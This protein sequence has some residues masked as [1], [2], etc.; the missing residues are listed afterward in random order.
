MTKYR[1]QIGTVLFSYLTSSP[2]FNGKPTGKHELTLILDEEQAVDAENAGLGIKR[3]EYNGSEQVTVKLTS[4][5]KLSADSVRDRYKNPYIGEDGQIKEIPKGST[6]C[7]HYTT[8]EYNIGGKVIANYLSGVQ[9]IEENSALEF[10]DYEES[11]EH[12]GEY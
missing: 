5:F 7:V 12:D 8:K 10:D 2:V 1:K 3:R 4:Q 9:V 6:V 11:E